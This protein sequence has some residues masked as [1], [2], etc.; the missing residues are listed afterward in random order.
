[1]HVQSISLPPFLPPSYFSV[2]KLYLLYERSMHRDE[3]IYK[4]K[5]IVASFCSGMQ[6]HAWSKQDIVL[7]ILFCHEILRKVMN[8]N[9]LLVQFM[10]Q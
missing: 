7:L 8:S 5:S 9:E 10:K 6:T 4:M 2:G 3:A 1:M